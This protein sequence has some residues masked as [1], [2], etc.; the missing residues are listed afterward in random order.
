[1]RTEYKCQISQKID[2][3]YSSRFVH[4]PQIERDTNTNKCQHLSL[5]IFN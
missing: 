4:C 1:M 5:P 3:A 2:V